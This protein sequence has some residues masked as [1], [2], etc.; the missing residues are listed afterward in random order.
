MCS[1]RRSRPQ[2][3]TVIELML[4]VTVIG[5][6]A[7]VALPSFQRY[8]LRSRQTERAVMLESIR[9]AVE[10]Y[11]ARNSRFPRDLGAGGSALSLPANPDPTVTPQKRPFRRVGPAGDHWADLSLLVDG[12]V[13]Y[14]YW[15]SGA[16]AGQSRDYWLVADGDLDG[17][18]A[19]NR[20]SRRFLYAGPDLQRLPG[21][22]TTGN[23]SFDVEIPAGGGVF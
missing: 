16:Q 20:L 10:D 18:G 15:G 3:F 14:V 9:R 19:T 2:G 1:T 21:G 17:D 11:S 6:L 4:V 13:Y 12:S 8:Q 7:S 5:L 22:A 23:W